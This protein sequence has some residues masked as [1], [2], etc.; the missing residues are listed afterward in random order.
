MSIGLAVAGN[1]NGPGNRMKTRP[2]VS[3]V[4]AISCLGSLAR[5]ETIWVEGEKPTKSTM[6]RH[7][8]WYDQV[9]KDQ[10]SGGDWISNFAEKK[11]PGEAEY[12]VAA[13]AGGPFEFWVRANPTATKLSFRINDADWKA[14][15]FGKNSRDATNIASDGK[16]DLRFIAWV[17]VG[18]VELRRGSNTIRF[19]MHS[20]NNN[21]GGLDCFVLS[22]EPFTPRG[23]LKPGEAAKPAMSNEKDWFAFDPSADA[24]ATSSAIDMRFLN[25]KAAGE[26][27]M[28]TAKDGRFVHSQSGEPVR[29]WAVNGAAA[30]SREELEREARQLAKYGVNLVRLHGPMFDKRGEVDPAKIERAFD[31]V[32]IMKAQGIYTHFS[33]YF[34]LWFDPP[35]DLDWMPGYDGKSHAFATLYFNPEFQEKYRGWWKAL[36]TTPSPTTGKRLVDDPAVFGLE[37]INE[38]SFFFWTFNDKNIP[39]RQLQFLERQ[40]AD[41]LKT[42]Y[43][44]LEKAVAAWNGQKIDRDALGEGRVGFR[45][46]WNIA[47]DRTPR[48]R[49]TARFLAERQRRFYEETAGFLR[50][51]GFRGLITASNWATASP[52]IFGPIEK[53]TYTPGDFIDRHGYFGCRNEGQFS[54][55]SIREGHSWADRSALRFDSEEPGKPASF[56]H[57]AMDPSYDDKPSMISETTW[58]RPN[59][60]R[61]EAP[62][63]LAA[64]GALQDS[65][66]IVH[67]AKDGVDWSVKPNYF[68]QP[69]TLTA[70]T[71]LGQFPAAALIYRRGLVKIGDV[72]ADLTLGVDDLMKLQGTPLPQ[73]AAF[74]ELRLKDI[75]QGATL[76]QGQRIDPLIHYV[77]RTRVAFRESAAGRQGGTATAKLQP[78][79]SFADHRKRFVTSST[80]ELRLDW[81]KGV[82]TIN[83]PAAQ[84]A[85]GDLAAAGEITLADV[86][87]SVPLDVAHVVVVSLDDRPLAT[88]RRMLLQVMTEEKP[89]NFR[90]EALGERRHRIV[91]IGENPWLVRNVEGA[92]RMRCREAQGHGARSNGPTDNDYSLG[93]RDPA[94]ARHDVLSDRGSGGRLVRCQS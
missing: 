62:L 89:T 84:G 20:D 15:D 56:M 80:R 22:T 13:A 76:G 25:E 44:S 51:L 19:R 78:L 34:P 23:I 70:P 17:K 91:S 83:A 52:E 1:S 77:G 50:G 2:V 42:R 12:T 58:N 68:M 32:E 40:F 66:A 64:Y 26:H 87:L 90:S 65:D 33:I 9:K 31:V 35:A 48:D 59:R 36:L 16:L 24:F 72:M 61:G 4:L 71:Q 57:P 94:A 21:H 69:W 88:A 30:K 38:D 7:P 60:H 41:W 11:E 93:R 27:G 49:D 79:A 43:G 18:R 47:H 6:N 81:G 73:D 92:V 39:N 53:F 29:F 75:P 74:D 8:W 85:S 46:L 14:I 3:V 37:I 55:W 54:E 5:A 63:Y 10:L 67:F 45:P 82:L 86:T 28:I